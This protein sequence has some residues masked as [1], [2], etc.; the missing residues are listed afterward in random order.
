MSNITP[1]DPKAQQEDQ[2]LAVMLKRPA[3][4][5]RFTEV[6]GERSAQFVSS[7]ISIGNT[8]R[9]VEPKSIIAS[10]MQAAA[11]DLPIEKSLGFAWIVPFKK[12][13]V[14]YAQFQ[15]G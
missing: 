11:L 12:G 4:A 6:L 7:L 1:F 2:S 3:Y 10:A 15:M 8:M 9:D 14:K 13:G 5:S